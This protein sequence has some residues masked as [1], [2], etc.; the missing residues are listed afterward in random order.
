MVPAQ[1]ST[2]IGI[3]YHTHNALYG[4]TTVGCHRLGTNFL[5]SLNRLLQY[6]LAYWPAE[7]TFRWGLAG[8][9][10]AAVPTLLVLYLDVAAVVS[11]G[12]G[13][14]VVLYYCSSTSHRSC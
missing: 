8:F 13:R 1:G 10:Q 5:M 4:Y 2:V 12:L 3:S 14:S 11:L 6:S 9:D 7:A